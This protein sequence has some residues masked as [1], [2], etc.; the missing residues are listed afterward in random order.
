MS[1]EPHMK[2]WNDLSNEEPGLA[3]VG[4]RLLFIS[5]PHVGYAFLAT[6]RKD[7][8][9]RLH[10][11]SVVIFNDHLYVIIPATSP[12]H[13]DFVRDGR[14]ALQVFPPTPNVENEEFYMAG[15]ADRIQ[16]AQL[17]NTLIE[18]TK[19]SVE[20]DEVLFELLLDRVMYTRLLDQGTSCE[21]PVHKK[22]RAHP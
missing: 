14:Y 11:I 3:E 16:D 7:G 19:V 1:K 21:R 9:P 8:A 6:L 13:A 20:K 18:Q 22:W 5:R 15:R 4:R 17:I 2:T 12:K 10:P